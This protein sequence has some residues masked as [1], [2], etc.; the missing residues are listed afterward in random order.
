MSVIFKDSN[1]KRTL[2]SILNR[3]KTSIENKSVNTNKQV[4]LSV[5]SGYVVNS[6]SQVNSN[7]DRRSFINSY[8]NNM[9]PETKSY[10]KNSLAYISE[11]I[12]QKVTERCTI[13]NKFLDLEDLQAWER[14]NKKFEEKQNDWNHMMDFILKHM[15]ILDEKY[16][17]YNHLDIKNLIRDQLV[18]ISFSYIILD[19]SNT[20]KQNIIEYIKSLDTFMIE[21]HQCKIKLSKLNLQFS[22][23]QNIK[24]DNFKNI[25][26]CEQ[27]IKSSNISHNETIINKKI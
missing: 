10:N 8:T 24:K 9:V 4:P 14:I 7:D 13:K 1:K 25:A 16:I 20:F 5:N 26:Q 22:K 27:K 2:F 18:N 12:R 15:I 3:K 23:Y 21:M 11:T 6:T 19:D 17:Q